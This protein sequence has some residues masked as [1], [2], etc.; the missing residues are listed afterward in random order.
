MEICHVAVRPDTQ[1]KGLGRTLIRHIIH[2]ARQEGRRR[3]QVTAR[4]TSA[5]FFEK[6]GFETLPQAI[7]DHPDFKKHGI[8]FQ[9]MEVLLKPEEFSP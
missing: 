8:S 1:R 7:P 6:L 4:N 9:V 5:G 2:N 3:I